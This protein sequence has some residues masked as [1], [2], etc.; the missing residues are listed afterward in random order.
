MDLCWQ[1][2][3]SLLNMLSRLVITFLPRSKHL[4]ISRLQSS[5][6]VILESPKIK[7]G[8]RTY[9]RF[10][11]HSS[12]HSSWNMNIFTFSGH[13]GRS[14]HVP[15]PQTFMSHFL[16][17]FVLSQSLIS[18]DGLLIS[19]DLGTSLVVQWLRLYASNPKLVGGGGGLC[20][21][22]GWGI[23]SCMPQLRSSTVK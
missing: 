13:S 16:A 7:S 8:K 6:A 19:I 14:I 12:A 22:P 23:G 18:C 1:S 21:I 11:G 4:L 5:S 2:N 9:I 20:S 15:L 10:E 3:V 17:L